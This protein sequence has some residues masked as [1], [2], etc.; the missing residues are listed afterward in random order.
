MELLKL[1]ICNLF[2]SESYFQRLSIKWAKIGKIIIPHPTSRTTKPGIFILQAILF[3]IILKV[4]SIYSKFYF[5]TKFGTNCIFEEMCHILS[6]YSKKIDQKHEISVKM[7]ILA[8]LK[9]YISFF[10]IL[11]IKIFFLLHFEAFSE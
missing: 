3:G 9:N 4:S 11:I 8:I 6:I 10:I 5:S 2:L 1:V 7:Y